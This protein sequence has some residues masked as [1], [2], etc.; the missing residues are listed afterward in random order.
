MYPGCA[1]H[2]LAADANDWT[3]G[4]AVVETPDGALLYSC[5]HQDWLIKIDYANGVGSGD[6]IWRLGKEGDFTY[7]STDPYP[8]FPISTTPLTSRGAVDHH[9]PRQREWRAALYLGRR[10]AG[11]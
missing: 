6:V 11:R 8:W 1:T 3:H 5:R 4:N 2:Y 9:A 7:D 10:A